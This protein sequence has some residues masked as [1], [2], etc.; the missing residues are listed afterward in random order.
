MWSPIFTMVPPHMQTGSISRL[1]TR[2]RA[3]AVELEGRFSNP[4]HLV[5]L[6]PQ[7]SEPL[8]QN[9]RWPH[10]SQ[11]VSYLEY[12]QLTASL[13]FRISP[14]EKRASSAVPGSLIHR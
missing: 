14:N 5:E 4:S 6:R 10:I 7:S 12:S 3:T 1:S 8:T 9:P 11:T 2:F 13:Q